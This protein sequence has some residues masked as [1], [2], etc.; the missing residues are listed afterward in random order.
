M[1][2]FFADSERCSEIGGHLKQRKMHNCLWGMD[3]S[4]FNY[5]SSEPLKALFMLYYNTECIVGI[6]RRDFNRIQLC[7]LGRVGGWG[8]SCWDGGTIE[9]RKVLFRRSH[10]RQEDWQHNF[11][12]ELGATFINVYFLKKMKRRGRWRWWGRRTRT[13][14]T[15]IRARTGTRD[16]GT[17]SLQTTAEDHSLSRLIL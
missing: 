4:V 9:R 11:L 15:T 6:L 17:Y 14:R 7:H 5:T 12:L 10:Y 16:N 13:S 2:K 3:A 1:W 8:G